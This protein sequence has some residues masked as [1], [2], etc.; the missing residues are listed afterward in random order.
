MLVIFLEVFGSID[1]KTFFQSTEMAELNSIK[2][3]KISIYLRRSP[4]KVSEITAKF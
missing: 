1:L 4:E 3:A 2:V